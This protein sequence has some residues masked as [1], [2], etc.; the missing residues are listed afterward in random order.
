MDACVFRAARDLAAPE[1][2]APRHLLAAALRDPSIDADLRAAGVDVEALLARTTTSAADDAARLREVESR[3]AE[4]RRLVESSRKQAIAAGMSPDDPRLAGGETEKMARHVAEQFVGT[5][6]LPG[7]IGTK[8]LEHLLHEVRVRLDSAQIRAAG[9]AEGDR[10]HLR[11]L[12][13]TLAPSIAASPPPI[14]VDAAAVANALLAAHAEA[15]LA[16]RPRAARPFHGSARTFHEA[17]IER[18]RTSRL[19]HLAVAALITLREYGRM[20][21]VAP[22]SWDE[23][24]TALG[25]A[26]T[27]APER[28]ERWGLVSAEPGVMEAVTAGKA[29]MD[30]AHPAPCD[31]G[32]RWAVAVLSAVRRDDDLRGRIDG[33]THVARA[34]EG[35]G[36]GCAGATVAPPTPVFRAL[37]GEEARLEG[38]SCLQPRHVVVAALRCIPALAAWLAAPDA[39]DRVR[40][41]LRQAQPDLP[42]IG[43]G[44]QSQV[45]RPVVDALVRSNLLRYV[46]WWP[47]MPEAEL[48]AADAAVCL[49]VLFADDAL[50]GALD[51]VGL[52]RDVVRPAVDASA[53]AKG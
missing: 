51:G 29:A 32:L 22:R 36:C 34:F 25:Y 43:V 30:A 9:A 20:P 7:A 49:D 11:A 18:E 42:T 12:V 45:A 41:A 39:L 46:V 10:L 16:G 47:G 17:Q 13:A 37:W 24:R 6:S 28:G 33:L 21:G 23:I 19:R 3:L 35:I 44:P 53:R 27:V 15:F 14:A 38:A 8:R 31:P 4:A 50:A 40:A 2:V 52:A 48:Q 1:P 5:D 26:C